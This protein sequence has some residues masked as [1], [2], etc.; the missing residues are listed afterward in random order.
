MINRILLAV[1]AALFMMQQPALAATP[2]KV[3]KTM[4]KAIEV[5]S[6]AQAKAD[7]W[8]VDKDDLVNE[9]R[10]LQTRLTWLEYQKGKHKI[11]VKGLQDNIAELETKKLEAR[12]LRENLEPYLDEVV[13]RLEAFIAT[14]MPFLEQERQQRLSFLYNTLND[15]QL[16]LGEKL[17]RVFESLGVE[18][19]YGKMVT[20]SDETLNIDG[21]DTEVTIFRLGRMAMYYQSMDKVKIGK[22]NMETKKW[23]PMSKDFARQIRHAV[24]MANRERTVQL[25]QLPVGAL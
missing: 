11:Y 18:A 20:A 25:I 21:D 12:K 17:R 7:D 10:D 22:W 6:K 13:K 15:Y 9:I 5:E 19:T 4:T 1:V 3:E 16:D 8:N 23:E 24:E 2:K 14:D